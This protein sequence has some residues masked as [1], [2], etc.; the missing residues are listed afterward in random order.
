M[1][2]RDFNCKACEIR[3]EEHYYQVRD[4]VESPVKCKCGGIMEKGELSTSYAKTAIFPYTTTHIS[5]DGKPVTVE[6]IGHLRSLEK[7]YGVSVSGFSQNPNN[8]DSP[9]DLPEQRPGGEEYRGPREATKKP[10]RA[11]TSTRDTVAAQTALRDVPKSRARKLAQRQ[12]QR[13]RET[14]STYRRRTGR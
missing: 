5:G 3:G 7:R 2:L 13:N 9:R 4:G 11:T 6:S 10:E 12:I 1:P 8:P 14:R